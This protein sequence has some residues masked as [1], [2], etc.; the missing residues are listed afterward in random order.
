[1][2]WSRRQV[3]ASSGIALAGLAGC[4]GDP[5]AEGPTIDT[6]PNY[7]DW[8][9]GVGNYRGT[10]DHRGASAVTVEVGVQGDLGYYKFGPAAIAV[11]PETNV[12]WEWTGKGG[13]HNVVALEGA[14]RSG[15]PVGD[16]GTTFSHRF[17]EPAIY[18]YFC[19]PHRGLGMRGALFVALD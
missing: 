6:E 17:E 7:R 2:D 1:M 8:F 9:D 3:L 19:T 14:F 5:L 18:K 10:H 12:T 11:S 13:Q 4:P 15:P 16:A